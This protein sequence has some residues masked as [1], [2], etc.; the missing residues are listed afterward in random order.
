MKDLKFIL[1]FFLLSFGQVFAQK[2]NVQKLINQHRYNEVLLLLNNEKETI[3]PLRLKALS[4]EKLFDYGNAI[5]F[6]QKIVDTNPSDIDALINLAEVNEVSGNDKSAL[7]NW[8]KI[9]KLQPDNQ[10]FQ[11]RLT[12]AYYKAGAWDGTIDAANKVLNKDSVPTVIRWVGDAYRNKND[13]VQ[14]NYYYGK[15]LEKNP[16]DYKSLARLSDYFY[17]LDKLGYDTLEVI[18][19]KYLT[20]IDSNQTVI[21]Q[22]NGMALYGLGKFEQAIDRF[23]KN[24]AL[25]DSSYTTLFYMGMSSFVHGHYYQANKWLGKAYEINAKDISLG[26]YY[27]SSLIRTN[28][29]K[30]GIE[31]LNKVMERIQKMD[32]LKGKIYE[33]M[34][35]GYNQSG[36][37]KSA[38]SYY[39]KV[40]AEDKSQN[41]ILYDI[42]VMFDKAKDYDNALGYYQRF[43]KTQPAVKVKEVTSSDSKTKTVRLEDIFYERAATRIDELKKEQFFKGNNK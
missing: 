20:K 7:E 30:K 25:G 36:N 24:I 35:T 16:S 34:A 8:I 5:Q 31:V 40:Y 12:Q 10:Y 37:L 13:I 6:Y 1:L 3:E 39:Q 15:A 19:N 9:Q 32:E 43:V 27:G 23:S 22:Y 11:L 14:A 28:E 17:N 42:A 4:Y 38:L 41:S 18:T 21:G 2:S 29:N 26:F 33:I